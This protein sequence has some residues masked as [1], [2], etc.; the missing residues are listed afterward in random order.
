M[1]NPFLLLQQLVLSAVLR[2]HVRGFHLSPP[3]LSFS[4][5]ARRVSLH[6]SHSPTTPTTTTTTT[7]PSFTSEEND[8]SAHEC[9]WCGSTFSSRNSLF[10]HLRTSSAC[11]QL[12]LEHAEDRA[13]VQKS[14][15]LNAPKRAAALL[16]GYD[17][18]AGGADLVERKVRAAIEAE[19]GS[20]PTAITRA[21]ATRHRHIAMAQEQSCPAAA[22]VLV[23][24][25]RSATPAAEK[26]ME[27]VNAQLGGGDSPARVLAAARLPPSS[28]LHAEASSTQIAYH[29]LLP[30]S[31]LPEGRDA[32]TWLSK[33]E[34]RPQNISQAQTPKNNPRF[35]VKHGQHRDRRWLGDPP[36]ALKK[37]KQSLK[38]ASATTRGPSS[39]IFSSPMY[40]IDSVDGRDAQGR[41][42]Q[43]SR[44]RFGALAGK[45]RRCC[46]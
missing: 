3:Q 8:A 9:R 34:T 17:Q 13:E 30:L 5:A 2:H 10:R 32:D 27:G 1:K 38:A 21:S 36:L 24:G 25:Y 31:W 20:P 28:R 14:L 19:T 4:D 35:G 15:T 33:S 16:V 7:P 37:L 42:I 43:K 11:T 39:P 22:D 12:A 6:H 29:Y 40:T 18:W 41:M 26:L 44:G 45:E 23:V 46:A